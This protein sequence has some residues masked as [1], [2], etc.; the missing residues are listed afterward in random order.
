VVS[1]PK[2]AVDMITKQAGDKKTDKKISSASE[3]CV[4]LNLENDKCYIDYCKVPEKE[5]QKMLVK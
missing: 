5:Q 4:V 1:M 2:E 3:Y